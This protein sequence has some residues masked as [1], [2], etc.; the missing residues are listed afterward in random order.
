MITLRQL[1][2]RK[3]TDYFH[4][5][6]DRYGVPTKTLE[7]CYNEAQ[8]DYS[9]SYNVD[10]FN[11]ELQDR[12]NRIMSESCRVVWADGTGDDSRNCIMCFTLCPNPVHGETYAEISVKQEGN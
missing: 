12:T 3:A 7:E 1:W 2:T 6:R 11:R 5:S 8:E 4:A 9:L 10:E